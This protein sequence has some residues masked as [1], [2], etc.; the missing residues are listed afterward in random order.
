MRLVSLAISM[1]LLAGCGRWVGINSARRDVFSDGLQEQRFP[2]GAQ[3]AAQ[4]LG[5]QLGITR[6]RFR[7]PDGEMRWGGCLHERCF[8]LIE[9][10][11]LTR[12]TTTD[13]FSEADL[14]SFWQPLDRVSLGQFRLELGERIEDKLIEQESTFVPRWGVT[15]GAL[16]SISTDRLVRGAPALG[17]RLGLRRWFNVHLIGHAAI[18]YRFGGD[19]ELSFRAGFE[20]ARWTEGR[21]WG[22]AGAP[23]ASVSFFIG[24]VFG[25]PAFRTALRTGVGIHVTDLSS[26]PFFFEVAAETTFAGESSRVV[27]SFTVGVGI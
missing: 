24:P 22:I 3:T 4:K 18:E 12:L 5:D 8:Q 7:L 2:M 20:V 26:A 25:F 14:I 13:N 15:L 6:R 16:G 27:G 10:D 23:P 17:G 9:E 21:L 19:H 11:G 1:L